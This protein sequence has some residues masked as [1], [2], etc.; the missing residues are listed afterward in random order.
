MDLLS[1]K[2]AKALD[3]FLVAVFIGVTLAFT[4]TK[5][6]NNLIDK[7]GTNLIIGWEGCGAI[8]SSEF[9]S[10]SLSKKI[11]SSTSLPSTT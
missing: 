11:S 7:A 4:A 2:E 9:S 3:F 6:F 1:E 5:G 10:D 8:S